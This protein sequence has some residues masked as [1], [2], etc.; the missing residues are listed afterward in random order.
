[1]SR[2]N[3]SKR[4]GSRKKRKLHNDDSDEISL[5]RNLDLCIDYG[6]GVVKDSQTSCEGHIDLFGELI[7]PDECVT[8]EEAKNKSNKKTPKKKKQPYEELVDTPIRPKRV[9]IQTPRFMKMMKEA[10]KDLYECMARM[11][12]NKVSVVSTDSLNVSGVQHLQD[13]PQININNESKINTEN[14]DKDKKPQQVL[15]G[16]LKCFTN[17]KY[18][19]YS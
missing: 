7:P 14:N 17:I 18:F 16:K 19:I 11:S 15:E 10:Q 8:N 12:S 6:F 4:N 3:T 2:K 9:F 1:M 5:D 13:S